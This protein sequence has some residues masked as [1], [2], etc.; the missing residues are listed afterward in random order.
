[1]ATYL[2]NAATTPIDPR[3]ARAMRPCLEST[4]GNPSSMHG[5]GDEPPAR[6]RLI[7]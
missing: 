1:M 7:A 6:Q 4:F 3:V 5:A 2:D